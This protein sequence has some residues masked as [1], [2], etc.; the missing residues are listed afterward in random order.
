MPSSSSSPS[1]MSLSPCSTSVGISSCRFSALQQQQMTA[2]AV[3]VLLEGMHGMH[4]LRQPGVVSL[5]YS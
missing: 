1:A 2:Q 3:N 4:N 5:I